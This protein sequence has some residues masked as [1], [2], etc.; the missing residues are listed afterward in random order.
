MKS[1]YARFN[2]SGA[3]TSYLIHGVPVSVVCDDPETSDRIRRHLSAYSAEGPGTGSGVTVKISYGEVLYPVPLHSRRVL[4]YESIRAYYHSGNIYFTDYFS[5]LEI[6]PDKSQICGNLSP[7]TIKDFGLNIFVDLFFTL[8]LF[9]MLRFKGLY[10][11]HASA[12]E[13]PDGY[14]YLISGNAGSGK[15]SLTLSL[16]HAGFRFLSDDTV[17]IRTAGESGLEVLG[18]ARDF[19]LPRDLIEEH[20]FLERYKDLPDFCPRRGRKLLDPD[21][22]FP[23]SRL[24]S[25]MNPLVILFPRVG[26][27]DSGLEPLSAA[28]AITELLPQSLSVMFNPETAPGHLEALK[29]T[30]RHA[31]SFRLFNGPDLKG[32]P[33]RV[34][35]IVLRAR[36]MALEQRG[37][38]P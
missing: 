19:H 25:I 6:R 23:G 27:G 28:R 22:W 31:R 4:L 20:K 33:E 17:F 34:K 16:I 12:L 24:D 30:L 3:E 2:K 18:F 38:A 9:E 26:E 5:T 36:G 29:R 10:Y 11:L 13:D 1:G 35:D 32:S 7:N 21:K 37:A 14:G 15:T 8:A